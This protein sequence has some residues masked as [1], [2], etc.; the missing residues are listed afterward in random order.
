MQ[1]FPPPADKLVKFSN[2]SNYQFP[3]TRWSF[4]HGRELGPTANVWHGAG[5]VS[6]LPQ[7][8]RDLAALPLRDTNDVAVS[9]SDMESATYTDSILVLHQGKVIYEKYFGITKPYLPHIA[10]SVTKSFVGTLAAMLVEEGKLSADAPVT[11]YV[12]E[13][14]DSAYGDATVRQVMDMTI[15]VQ[16]SEA[17][18]DPKA[19]VWDYAR[20]GG[21]LPTKPDYAGPH[22]FYEFL[23]KLKKQGEHGQ[24]FAYKTANAEVLAW[25]VRRASGVSLADLL[26][27]RIWQ[28]LG[29]E[30]DAYFSVD[31]IGTEQGGGGL[32]LTLRDMARFGEMLR[33]NGKFNG[34]QIVPAAVVADIRKGGDPA[35]FAPA[36]YTSLPGYSYRNMWW[37]GHAG[38]HPFEARGIHGQRIYIDPAAQLVIVK[39]SSHPLAANGASDPI[40]YRA[41]QALANALMK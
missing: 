13:L 9:W 21:L 34:Q 1:G 16:Y 5:P 39:F 15:G 4:S 27:Q 19:E 7:A 28:K 30:N 24:V 26:S 38:H 31:S 14:K 6:V 36:G 25:I 2:G 32:N 23:V 40:T 33:L 37:V 8:L 11:D 29:T 12:P 41:F 18:A 17:Y 22:S 3:R 20:A 35:K 10:M